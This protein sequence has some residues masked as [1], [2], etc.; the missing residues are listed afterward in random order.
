MA[1][2]ELREQLV[3]KLK[4]AAAQIQESSLFQNLKEKY[5]D[6]PVAQQRAT[7]ITSVILIGLFVFS[8]PYTNWSLSHESVG[9]FESKRA[10]IRDLLKVTKE[11]SELPMLPPAPTTGQ[12]QT[13]MQMRIQSFQLLQE[14]MGPITPEEPTSSALIPA[15][16]Q[17]GVIKV[18]L[19]KLNLRQIVDITHD[20]QSMQPAVK[21]RNLSIDANLQDARYLDA[22]LE[23]IIVKIPQVNL[24][25]NTEDDE[26][27]RKGRGR[28]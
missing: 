10:L 5:D 7:L 15:N 12:I 13:D 19:K 8:F 21:L 16:R 14:Q 2:E 4:D 6:L 1:F 23:F 17:E 22:I 11:T 25:P 26:P 18:T 9:S 27:N 3:S 24:S 20:L 28:K